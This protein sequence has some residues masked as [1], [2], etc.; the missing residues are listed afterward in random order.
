MTET[1]TVQRPERKHGCRGGVRCPRHLDC[2]SPVTLSGNPEGLSVIKGLIV[3][4]K[5]PW[6][7]ERL[8]D[9]RGK[10]V[11]D[12]TELHYVFSQNGLI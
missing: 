6:W 4:L 8:S 5:L 10:V 2:T 12:W 11:T 9:S 7:P 3:G 1:V